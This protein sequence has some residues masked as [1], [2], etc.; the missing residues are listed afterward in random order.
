MFP[1]TRRSVA[2]S[3]SLT[4]SVSSG[5][6]ADKRRHSTLRGRT[7]RWLSAAA[8]A[9]LGMSGLGRTAEAIYVR[10]DINVSGYTNLL[11]KPA[12][13]PIGYLTDPDWAGEAF[14]SGTLVAPNK[15]LTAAHVVDENGDGKVDSLSAVRRMTF[16]L[17]R[18]IPTRVSANVASIVVNSK[19]K[20]SNSAFDLA[21]ITLKTPIT[22][23]TPATLF[24]GN[25]VG[26]RGG[27]VGY[28]FQGTG[29]SDGLARV[30]DK[31][32]A[33]NMIDRLEDGTYLTDFDNSARNRSSF[34]SSTPLTYEGTTAPGDSGSP[35]M[36]DMGNDVWRVAGVL[37]GGYN[38]KGND[39]WY[40]DVSIYASLN[41]AANISFLEAQGLRFADRVYA[42]R[43]LVSGIS[44]STRSADFV[45]PV[46]IPEPASI[47]VLSIAAGLLA[48]RR[49]RA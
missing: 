29:R 49:R 31:L 12:F 25:V 1:Q 2:R 13:A 20:G 11:N 40:G 44:G 14:A 3:V 42:N 39:S 34:G 35:L 46:A 28:G 24:S 4:A 19:Y 16:G 22:G 10:H 37:N 27:L 7:R 18:D 45:G 30:P 15:V 38:E 26:R 41:N 8:L 21:V 5:P 9:L 23:V 6:T 17:G 33:F 36:A 32:A 47:G 48:L 43:S